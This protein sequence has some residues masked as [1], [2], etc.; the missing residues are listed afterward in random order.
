[1]CV[2]NQ[3]SSH[4]LM[5]FF[6]LFSG[7]SRRRA[8]LSALLRLR[9]RPLGSSGPAWT[10]PAAESPAGIC[11]SPH[12]YFC[13]LPAPPAFHPEPAHCGQRDRRLLHRSEVRVRAGT[14]TPPLQSHPLR[15][16]RGPLFFYLLAAQPGHHPVGGADQI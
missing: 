2:C 15:H 7:V 9:L 3:R 8:V 16:H 11:G 4:L 13:L 6:L 1:M 14:P 12:S 10:L 5:L